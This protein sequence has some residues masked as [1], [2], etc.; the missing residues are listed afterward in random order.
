M[1]STETVNMFQPS[2]SHPTGVPSPPPPSPPRMVRVYLWDTLSHQVVAGPRLGL[3]RRGYTRLAFS[4]DGRLL[5][6]NE[7]SNARLWDAAS[8][9]P[10]R[11][12]ADGHDGTAWDEIVFSPDG[13][14]LATFD[15]QQ[16]CLWQPATLRTPPQTLRARRKTDFVRFIFSPDGSFLAAQRN[17]QTHRYQI[18]LF[19]TR[20]QD[21]RTN[22]PTCR[23]LMGW[24]FGFGLDTAPFSGDSGLIATG[25]YRYRAM[26]D[27]ATGRSLSNPEYL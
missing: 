18:F 2:P 23:E 5:A 15:E 12:P 3:G 6:T 27:T 7:R 24:P 17:F 8:R 10:V 26:V 19:D 21:A 22:S 4:P 9:Q 16:V 20:V 11:L 1:S 14:L 25:N 13:R